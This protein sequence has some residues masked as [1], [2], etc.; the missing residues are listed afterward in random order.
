MK[1]NI[2]SADR[3]VRLIGGALLVVIGVASLA[4]L[5]EFGTVAGVGAVLIGAIFL[6][7]ALTRVCLVYR[8]LGIETSDSS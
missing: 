8:L 4:G 6:G 7:T 2:G 5:L 1:H 3:V